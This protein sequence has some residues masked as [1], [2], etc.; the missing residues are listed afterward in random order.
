MFARF[1]RLAVAAVLVTLVAAVEVGAGVT[2]WV[3]A[4]AVVAA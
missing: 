2:G 1:S 4:V 3:G